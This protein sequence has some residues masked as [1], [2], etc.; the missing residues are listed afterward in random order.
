MNSLLTRSVQP[1]ETTHH[2]THPTPLPLS[3][4]DRLALRIGR[5]LIAHAERPRPTRAVPSTVRE[6]TLREHELTAARA[7]AYGPRWQ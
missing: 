3:P 5:W 4:A 6:D 1:T 2:L 7:Q